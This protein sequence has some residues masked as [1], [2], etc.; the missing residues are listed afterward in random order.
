MNENATPWLET[1]E[2][3]EEI[4][5][6]G[7]GIVTKL[8]H[9]KESG[10]HAVLK[11]IVERWRDD[12]QALERLHLEAETLAKLHKLGASVPNVYDSSLDHNDSDP[13]IVMEFID[14]LRFDKWLKKNKPISL[15]DAVLV[16]RGITKTITLCHQHK[17]GHRDLKPAN[18][19]L[20]DGKVETPYIIDFGIAFD[21]KQSRI[22]TRD[23]EIFWN[24]FIT[25]PE[26][27]ALEGG[28]RDLRSDIT[29]LAG[30]FFTCLTGKYPM[31]LRDEQDRSPHQRHRQD[32]QNATDL[33]D[34]RE[35]LFWFFDRAFSVRID[36]R[37]QDMDEFDSELSSFTKKSSDDNI[38]LIEEFDILDQKVRSTSREVQIAALRNKYQPA[39]SAIDQ[40]MQMELKALV[41]LNGRPSQS[42]MQ[43]DQL[44]PYDQPKI[45]GGDLL[46]GKCR[47]YS[48][49]RDHFQHSINAGIVAFGVG[50]QIHFYSMAFSTPPNIL[51]RSGKN[52][53]WIKVAV[54]D[55]DAKNLSDDKL[56][57]IV[58][59]LMKKLAIETRKI[60]R[61][62]NLV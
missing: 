17:I 30:I 34:K 58:H 43:L 1:W 9:K 25:L 62:Q 15:A 36:D 5:R 4:G 18:I 10:R 2:E 39:I 37:F 7:Q 26:C 24:E 23:G 57:L 19:I 50:M 33:M 11:Q 13:F 38:D 49:T 45:D 20:K 52:L 59:D 31:V 6:G 8:S 22:L 53:E 14:G 27:Q 32:L 41:Q 48:I 44:S 29:A 21:S 35:K 12:P 54:M 47:V 61:E 46:S 3:I 60:R 28:H 55:E 51:G 56:Y 16:T 42:K 40:K